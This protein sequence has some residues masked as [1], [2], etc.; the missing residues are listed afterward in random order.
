MI[1]AILGADLLHDIFVFN[2]FTNVSEF[3]I[4]STDTPTLSLPVCHSWHSDQVTLRQNCHHKCFSKLC[5]NDL[6]Q[7][8]NS[9]VKRSHRVECKQHTGDIFLWQA[10]IQCFYFQLKSATQRCRA[11]AANLQRLSIL[12]WPV[13]ADLT[14]NLNSCMLNVQVKTWGSAAR[15]AGGVYTGKVIHLVVWVCCIFPTCLSQHPLS[16]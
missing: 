1:C 13:P 7:I 16:M 9:S 5:C 6:P 3:E 12:L 10:Y 8:T 14:F 15:K 2:T 4:M 11:N